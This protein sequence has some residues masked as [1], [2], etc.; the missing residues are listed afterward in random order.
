MLDLYYLRRVKMRDK[1]KSVGNFE[2]KEGS[3]NYNETDSKSL[4]PK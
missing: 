2:I 4:F 3:V 1:S